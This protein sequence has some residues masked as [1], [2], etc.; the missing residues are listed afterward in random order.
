[1]KEKDINNLSIYRLS[2][3]EIKFE[4]KAALFIFLGHFINGGV[5]FSSFDYIT[6][7]VKII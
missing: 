6:F 1:L 3:I 7:C 5:F 4:N 2:M